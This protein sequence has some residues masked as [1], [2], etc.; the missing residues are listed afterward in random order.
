ML[1]SSHVLHEVEAVCDRV[2]ILRQGKLVHLQEMSELRDGRSVSA[3][4]I[5]T[6]PTSGPDGEGL[7]PDAI[8]PDGRLSMT[9][10]GPMPA[11][12]EWLAKQRL[13]DLRIEPLGLAPIYRKYHG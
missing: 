11:L 8:G 9:Y 5:E 12:L 10:R 6:I 7:P 1:F 2:G 13:D 3:R 4:I